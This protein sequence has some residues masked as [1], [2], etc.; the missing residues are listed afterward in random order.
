[1]RLQTLHK[2]KEIGLEVEDDIASLKTEIQLC[3]DQKGKEIIFNSKVKHLEEGEKCT[4]FFFKKVMEKK[5]TITCLDGETTVE[6]KVI[7]THKLKDLD[8]D[9]LLDRRKL[10]VHLRR[11]EGVSP[12]SN[13]SWSRSKRV[14]RNVFGKFLANIHKDLAWMAARQC[15]PTRDFQHRRGLAARAKTQSYDLHLTRTI[16]LDTEEL[17]RP[18]DIGRRRDR[19]SVGRRSSARKDLEKNRAALRNLQEG[20]P[21]RQ[22]PFGESVQEKTGEESAL[23][24][25]LREEF[26]IRLQETPAGGTMASTGKKAGKNL[27]QGTTT[28][29]QPEASSAPKDSA[30]AAGQQKGTQKPRREAPTLEPW[31]RQTVALKLKEVD[32]RVP[33]MSPD[34]FSRKM[35]LE[36][37]FSTSE[38]LCVQTFLTGIFFVTFATV[39]ACRRFWEMVSAGGSDPSLSAFTGSCP[40]QREERRITVSM[41]NPHTPGK[42]IC[43][44]LRRFCLVVREP[45]HILNGCSFWTGKWSVTVR[46]HRDP[47]CS[48]RLQHLPPTFSLG[49]S[50]GLIYYPDMPRNCRRCGKNGHEMKDCKEDACRTC[51]VTGH[52][53][54]D[55]P[56]RTSCNLC[57][58]ADHMYKDCPKRQRSWAS[59]AAGTDI[60][61][62]A[63]PT[64]EP[65]VAKVATAKAPVAT[66]QTAKS[67]AGKESVTGPPAVVPAAPKPK[68]KKKTKKGK[69]TATPL[70]IPPPATPIPSLPTPTTPTRAST[71]TS[72]PYSS[73]GVLSPAPAATLPPRPWLRQN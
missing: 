5:E 53:S 73:A 69:N 29:A 42:D 63:L 27:E 22:G 61:E 28:R 20:K 60:W 38:T 24:H 62:T 39:N 48:D 72:F 70:L 66:A 67:K 30:S 35:L 68:E 64:T 26:Q 14:W 25:P 32:G 65:V 56:R 34:M 18:A 12:V 37:G 49:N 4:R 21:A 10:M 13:F 1:M 15:L 36:R 11:E 43:T 45:T 47:A 3:L 57:G 9:L 7:R 16:E 44:F 59:V 52:S 17:R 23:L 8:A 6:E 19:I 58:L 31:M 2:F 54:K 50:Y 55:C 51:R 46:L 40:I 33:D 71:S 41:R